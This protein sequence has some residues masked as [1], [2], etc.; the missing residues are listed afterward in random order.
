MTLL[1]TPLGLSRPPDAAGPSRA[2]RPA[3]RGRR[4]ARRRTRSR[5]WCAT[6]R[7]KAASIRSRSAMASITSASSATSRRPVGHDLYRRRYLDVAGHLG[8]GDARRRRRGRGHRCGDVG[9]AS[10]RLRR[11]AP[12]RPSRRGHQADGLLLLRQCRDRRAP[13]PAQIR[14]R[15][16]GHGRFRRPSR[17]RH[18]GHFLGRSD[19]DVLLDPPDAAVS[20]HRRPRRARR[21][22]HY[23]QRAAGVGRRRREIPLRVREPDPAAA[24]RSSAR[25]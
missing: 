24:C 19:R 9:R 25:N 10:K 6:R 23:R 1:L 13:R 2:P 15:A 4:G 20:G 16:R 11:G 8:S 21:A 7:R 12:A 17:Q 14:H 3:A 18:A 22:R 5:L